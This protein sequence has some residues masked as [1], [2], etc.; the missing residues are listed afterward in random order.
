MKIY[1]NHD[2]QMAAYAAELCNC[3]ARREDHEADHDDEGR[4]FYGYCHLTECEVFELAEDEQHSA[5]SVCDECARGDFDPNE[6]PYPSR[7]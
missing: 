4:M 3:G 1:A 7:A 6:Q 2:L 5:R